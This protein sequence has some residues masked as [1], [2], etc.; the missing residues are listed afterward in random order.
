MRSKGQHI[1]IVLDKNG[2]TNGIITL[3]NLVECLIG[4]IQDEYDGH[5]TQPQPEA[6]AE[7]IEIK[8]EVLLA[9]L[10]ESKGI[11]LPAGPYETVG[12][13]VTHYLG[14]I[15][16]VNDVIRINGARFTII[17]MNGKQIGQL[18]LARDNVK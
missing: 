9:D 5:E 11:L 4:Q 6:L 2:G 7:D 17:S 8:G 13:F 10:L 12:G 1:A 16:Q 14:R 15:A 18:L 3:E